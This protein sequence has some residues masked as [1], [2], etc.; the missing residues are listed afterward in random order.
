MHPPSQGLLETLRNKV[1]SH[2]YHKRLTTN[3]ASVKTIIV[4]EP[5]GPKETRRVPSRFALVFFTLS[6]LDHKLFL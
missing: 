3:K 2:D 4:N 6:L 5:V 1:M